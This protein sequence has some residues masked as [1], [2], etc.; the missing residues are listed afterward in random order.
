M[1]IK[2]IN[3]YDIKDDMHIIDEFGVITNIITNKVKKTRINKRG[4]VITDL[5]VKI[6]GKTKTKTFYIHRLVARAFLGKALLSKNKTVNHKN[7]IKTDNHYTNLEWCSYEKQ[8][9]HAIKHNL[10]DNIMCEKHHNSKYSNELIIQ[11]NNMMKDGYSN[12][13]IREKLALSK[14]KSITNL[15]YDIRHKNK[16]KKIL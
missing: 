4:Y 13:K 10:Y 1:K 3:F 12:K 5:Q 11:I 8:M 15:L 6:D 16:W 7:T 14:T 2:K 9:R